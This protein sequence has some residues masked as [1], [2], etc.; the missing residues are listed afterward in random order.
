MQSTCSQ[1]ARDLPALPDFI[2]RPSRWLHSGYVPFTIGEVTAWI[3]V[4]ADLPID[5][6]DEAANHTAID[7]RFRSEGVRIL[8]VQCS[9]TFQTFL[10]ITP[11][12]W[13]ADLR[14]SPCPE[15]LLRLWQT[16]LGVF[17][18]YVG[19]KK[20]PPG[21]ATDY[22]WLIIGFCNGGAEAALRERH[23]RSLKPDRVRRVVDEMERYFARPC[24]AVAPRT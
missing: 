23:L 24:P 19:D 14:H 16:V 5:P 15:T 10:P 6:S 3:Y 18:Y 2:D 7:E 21:A 11:A 20:L 12:Q 1:S 8:L 4:R 13:E 9:K 22:F 17:S